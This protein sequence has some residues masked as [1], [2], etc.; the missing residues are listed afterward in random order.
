MRKIIF[1][2]IILLFVNKIKAQILT[3]LAVVGKSNIISENPAKVKLPFF[4]LYSK[5]YFKDK[6][7]MDSLAVREMITKKDTLETDFSKWRNQDFPNKI[8]VP[9]NGKIEMEDGLSKIS[10]KTKEEKKIIQKEIKKYNKRRKKWSESPLR[11]SRPIYTADKVYALMTILKG[12]SGG[13]TS[14]F[15][16]VDGKW[17]FVEY[18]EQWEY[19]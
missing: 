5:P 11:V 4:I 16:K 7:E 1:I 6:N 19:E 2:I 18:L 17:T 3:N 9:I 12:N 13:S 8:L 14:L 15:K 10:W